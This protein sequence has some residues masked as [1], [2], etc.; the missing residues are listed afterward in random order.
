M[1]TMPGEEKGSVC[2]SSLM[3]LNVTSGF[4]SPRHYS[5]HDRCER[6]TRLP[7]RW[8]H[9]SAVASLVLVRRGGIDEV[10]LKKCEVVD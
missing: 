9:S 8:I 1:A 6:L 4:S 2:E 10:E 5:K 3:T 7:D